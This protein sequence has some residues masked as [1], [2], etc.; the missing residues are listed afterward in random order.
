MRQI[1]TH[2]T[3]KYYTQMKIEHHIEKIED[4][5]FDVFLTFHTGELESRINFALIDDN[6]EN[7]IK[8]IEKAHSYFINN[9]SI[10]NEILT[11]LDQDD[12]IERTYIKDTITITHKC[13]TFYFKNIAKILATLVSIK[14]YLEENK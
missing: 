12:R 2:T 8:F 11:I 14:E 5:Y 9:D 7:F 4:M 1:T 10:L 6:I 3:H 13:V